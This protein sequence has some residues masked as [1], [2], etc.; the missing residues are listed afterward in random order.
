MA[1]TPDSLTNEYKTRGGRIVRDGGGLT[2]DSTVTWSHPTQ[3]L[4]TLVRDNRIFDYAVEYAAKNPAPAT[5]EEI[6][7]TDAMYDDFV[8]RTTTDSL[9]YNR[10]WQ[11]VMP[12]LRNIL[13][14][15]GYLDDRISS[16]IDSLEKSLQV[17]L[18][19]DMRLKRDEISGYLAEDLAQ[20]WF[21]DR[22]KSIVR[23]RRDTG[24]DKAIEI[25]D[26]GLY[27][28]ILGRD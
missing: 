10:P 25:L 6:V 26:S 9:K 20:I 28:K 17:D 15:E 13:K 1:R 2:P 22:G 4:Y 18:A 23:L 3:L 8:K 16:Q 27:R 7:V 21:Y 19:E 14:D 5:P 11:D 12:R 24:L